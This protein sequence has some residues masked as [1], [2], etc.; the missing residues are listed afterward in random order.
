M[1]SPCRSSFICS[2]VGATKSSPG[3]R[4]VFCSRLKSRIPGGCASSNFCF[5]LCVLARRAFDLAMASVMPWMENVWARYGRRGAD[6]PSRAP[7]VHHLFVM[8]GSLSMTTQVDGKSWF[9]AARQMALRKSTLSARRRLH[10]PPHEGQP[11]L[12]SSAKPRQM[13][14]RS[15]ASRML[16]PDMATP[17]SRPRST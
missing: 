14:V 9:E 11:D 16:T 15:S 17:P 7:R 4:C 3:R 10:D 12:G 8:D 6:R 5:W 13:L 2:I 1:P